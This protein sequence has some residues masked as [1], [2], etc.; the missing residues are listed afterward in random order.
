[1]IKFKNI[2]EGFFEEY[3]NLS[4][5]EYFGSGEL[6]LSFEMPQNHR[7]YKNIAEEMPL[8][9]GGQNYI[10]KSIDEQGENAVI[11]C[12][13]DLDELQRAGVVNYR[14][15]E[16]YLSQ[17]L[18]F[19]LTGTGWTHK[20]AEK[21]TIRRTAELEGGNALDL[22]RAAQNV[23]KCVL[24]YDTQSKVITVHPISAYEYKGAYFTDELNVNEAL[25][26]GDSF[27]FCT[28]LIPIGAEGL[29]IEAV[30]G[31]KNYVDNFEYSDKIITK[32]W[33]DE[34]YTVAQ[35]LRDDAIERLKTLSKPLRTYS[36]DVI[37][38]AAVNSEY[39]HLKF[40]AGDKAALIDRNR[41]IK[42]EHQV[43]KTVSYPDNPLRNTAELAATSAGIDT[44]VKNIKSMIGDTN[45]SININRTK[46]TDIYVGIGEIALR[47][48]EMFVTGSTQTEIT[49]DITANTEAIIQAMRERK[50]SVDGD[51]R[52]VSDKASEI[53]QRIDSI[54]LS[55]TNG[56]QGSTL[57]LTANGIAAQSVNIMFDGVVNFINNNLSTF[58]GTQI[59]G[60]NIM[61]D[62]QITARQ[63]YISYSARFEG[64]DT[65]LT[66]LNSILGKN[67]GYISFFEKYPLVPK[68]NVSYSWG[69]IGYN[70]NDPNA[71]VLGSLNRLNTGLK[72]LLSA[73]HQYGL[74]NW[75]S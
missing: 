45:V 16:Q 3:T 71:V 74:I 68:Q 70:P 48:A 31:G 62:S 55:V 12:R 14:Q 24:Y 69:G 67:G 51:I 59:N 60:G 58:G 6:E 65:I 73:L 1:M 57:T 63:L 53:E 21:I 29:T 28:R 2:D 75:Q 17:V 13:F 22:L 18:N 47:L 40:K 50:T 54:R 30:N 27:D 64:M 8:V 43:V 11:S 19:A 36:L 52:T 10:I 66:G 26:R 46:T 72:D 23:F 39:S 9:Y 41:N 33:K 44:L 61:A 7:L 56:Q 37:D 15:T 5:T 25:L 32:V 42:V 49:T 20:S 38:L 35:N 34:R 4:I